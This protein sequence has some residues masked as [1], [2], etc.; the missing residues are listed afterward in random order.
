MTLDP[1][2]NIDAFGAAAMLIAGVGW[3]RPV[4]ARSAVPSR[5]RAVAQ[6]SRRWDRS[7]TWSSPRSSRSRC[8]WSC[9]GSAIDPA[10]LRHPRAVHPARACS[11][12]CCCR[13]FSSTSRCSSST[14]CRC[15]GLDG[16]AVVR[17]LLFSRAPQSASSTVEQYR[18]VLYAAVAL[19]ALLP[20][21][22]T[23]GAVNPIASM[24]IGTGVADLRAP[25]RSRR[26]RRSSSACPNVF[27][28]S[29]MI[30]VVIDGVEWPVEGAQVAIVRARTRAPPVPAVAARM[31]APRWS[32]RP[33]RGPRGDR[34]ARGGGGDRL[35]RA[36]RRHRRRVL[37]ARAALR[38]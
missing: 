5:S 9:S 17:S 15:P 27:T 4:A 38:R 26:A 1:R 33:R 24:T 2:R 10:G 11:S 6:R 21:Q 19:A 25:D 3:G 22:V 14:R 32:L 13:G 36:H 20:P 31:G 29:L 28:L 23:D 30:A 8:A 35:R 18:Y 16:Y 12:A 34:R 7:R 37:V